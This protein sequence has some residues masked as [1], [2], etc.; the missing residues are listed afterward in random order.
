MRFLFILLLSFLFLS[1]GDEA[2]PEENINTIKIIDCSSS[3][4]KNNGICEDV[5]EC[6]DDVRDCIK[7]SCTCKD[8]YNGMSCE[9]ENL[10][11]SQ[12]PTGVCKDDKICDNGVCIRDIE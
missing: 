4:C 2:T 5:D 9:I 10:C 3:P 8:G 12:Y 11:S 6:R 7:Y 1:C